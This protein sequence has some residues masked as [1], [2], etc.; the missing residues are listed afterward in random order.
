MLSCVL[1]HG[2]AVCNELDYFFIGTFRNFGV[3]R[4][5]QVNDLS[6]RSTHA[7]KFLPVSVCCTL[8]L[9]KG[10]VFIFN[11]V[12]NCILQLQ[13]NFLFHICYRASSLIN[14]DCIF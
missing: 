14:A 13:I 5:I 3:L 11:L 9:G 12:L 2:Q 6:R 4:T 8:Y 10:D 7:C 1:C